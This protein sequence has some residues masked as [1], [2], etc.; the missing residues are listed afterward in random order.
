MSLVYVVGR[1]RGTLRPTQA[2][3]E[4]VVAWDLVAVRTTEAAAVACCSRAHDFVA[5]VD[6]EA[7]PSDGV[8]LFPAVRWPLS[9]RPDP[10]PETPEVPCPSPP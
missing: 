5:T 8:E 1:Y 6:L 9:R 7:P 2:P 3:T 10:K 4:D